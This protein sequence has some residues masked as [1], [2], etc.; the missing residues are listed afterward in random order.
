MPL[1]SPLMPVPHNKI[2]IN[3]FSFVTDSILLQYMHI[4]F[5]YFYLFNIHI[6]HRVHKSKRKKRSINTD[7]N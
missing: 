4:L 7:N 1:I 3:I 5:I 2:L 6:V